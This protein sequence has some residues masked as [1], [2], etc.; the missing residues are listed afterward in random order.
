MASTE[1]SVII[2]EK[3]VV[4]SSSLESIV[5]V[6]KKRLAKIE[7]KAKEERPTEERSS[8]EEQQVITEQN[9]KQ[10]LDESEKVSILAGLGEALGALFTRSFD[11]VPVEQVPNLESFAKGIKSIDSWTPDHFKAEYKWLSTL[12]KDAETEQI[13]FPLRTYILTTASRKGFNPLFVLGLAED[14][15]SRI[16]QKPVVE[17]TDLE[18]LERKKDIFVADELQEK[19]DKFQSKLRNLSLSDWTEDDLHRAMEEWRDQQGDQEHTSTTKDI[20]ML[21]LKEITRRANLK[22][23]EKAAEKALELKSE[24]QAPEMVEAML[25]NEKQESA[26]AYIKGYLSEPQAVAFDAAQVVADTSNQPVDELFVLLHTVEE[27]SPH[28]SE[29]KIYSELGGIASIDLEEPKTQAVV[30]A[31]ESA[32]EVRDISVEEGFWQAYARSFDES[33]RAQLSSLSA[34]QL[35]Q[36]YGQLDHLV[37]E[38]KAKTKESTLRPKT[39]DD[40]F[41]SAEAF[42]EEKAAVSVGLDNNKVATISEDIDYV[43]DRAAAYYKTLSTA[44]VEK[45]GEDGFSEFLETEMR[46]K[47]KQEEASEERAAVAE[48]DRIIKE[49]RIQTGQEQRIWEELKRKHDV[50]E[51]RNV[52]ESARAKKEEIDFDAMAVE[53]AGVTDDTLRVVKAELLLGM[54]FSPEERAAL[55]Q[56]HYVGMGEKGK[57]GKAAGI[58]NYTNEQLFKKMQ[59]LKDA[60]FDKGQVRQLLWAGLAGSSGAA[61]AEPPAPTT[62]SGQ[63]NY[64]APDLDPQ[65]LDKITKEGYTPE[66]PRF[67][68][69]PFKKWE[70]APKLSAGEIASMRGKKELYT[71]SLDPH[72]RE[73]EY[74][75]VSNSLEQTAFKIGYSAPE[76]WGPSGKYPVYR[77]IIRG[78]KEEIISVNEANLR[79]WWRSRM[80]YYHEQSPTSIYD[81]FSKVELEM[82]LGKFNL[83]TILDNE[84]RTLRSARTGD[85]S[86]DLSKWLQLEPWL[87]S[88]VR[89][90]QIEYEKIMGQDAKLAEKIA[91]LFYWNPLTKFS[92]GK[93]LLSYASQLPEMEGSV[94]TAFN[95]YYNLSDH[96]K[97]VDLIGRDSAFFSKRAFVEALKAA[98][99]KN[100]ND[101][102]LDE[103]ELMLRRGLFKA[104]GM[105]NEKAFFPDID[106]KTGKTVKKGGKEQGTTGLKWFM[107]YVNIW[108]EQTPNPGRRLLVQNLVRSALV[109]KHQMYTLDNDGTYAE[110]TD[111]ASFAELTAYHMQRAFGGGSRNDLTYRSFDKQRALDGL[112]GVRQKYF[113]KER[114]A[115]AGNNY[116]LHQFK[117]LVVNFLEGVYT[118]SMRIGK[119]GLP[120]SAKLTPLE[121]FEEID[122]QT[123]NP[124]AKRKLLRGRMN[125][126]YKTYEKLMGSLQAEAQTWEKYYYYSELTKFTRGKLDSIRARL[127]ELQGPLTQWDKLLDE[128][129]ERHQD[130]LQ[131]GEVLDEALLFSRY[132]ESGSSDDRKKKFFQNAFKHKMGDIQAQIDALAKTNP[133]SKKLAKLR[134]DLSWWT[135][136]QNEINQ[137]ISQGGTFAVDYFRTQNGKKLM[138][139]YIEYVTAYAIP[140]MPGAVNRA[141]KSE[142]DLEYEA[143]SDLQGWITLQDQ[144]NDYNSRHEAEMIH[145]RQRRLELTADFERYEAKQEAARIQTDQL[146]PRNLTHVEQA[147]LARLQQLYPTLIHTEYYED[148]LGRMDRLDNRKFGSKTYKETYADFI[149]LT[150]QVSAS[151]KNI[152]AMDSEITRLEKES[153]SAN[154]AQLQKRRQERNAEEAKLEKAEADLFDINQRYGLLLKSTTAEKQ[155]LNQEQRESMREAADKLTFEDNTMRDWSNNHYGRAAKVMDYI[156][157][158]GELRLEKYTQHDTFKG[159]SFNREE[160]QKEFQENLSKTYRYLRSTY[161]K[162][163]YDKP[164]RSYLEEPEVDEKGKLQ[165]NDDGTVKMKRKWMDVPLGEALFGYEVVNRPE[166]W[167]LDANG[168]P[169]FKVV[170]AGTNKDGS[171]KYKQTKYHEI[172][173]GKVNKQK[174]LLW[175][176][177]LM[178]NIAGQLW[179]HRDWHSTDPRYDF[180]YYEKV[181]DVLA[182]IPASVGGD[183]FHFRNSRVMSYFFDKD[184]IKW[185]RKLS[186]TRTWDLYWPTFFGAM[187]TRDK[188]DKDDPVTEFWKKFFGSIVAQVA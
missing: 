37:Q 114:G 144:V 120:T 63:E 78:D 118:N 101:A 175:K 5:E 127:A 34:G 50:H 113:S 154:Q 45:I 28:M 186:N 89:Q 139:W 30:K 168:Q 172:D 26:A 64:F 179:A 166:F 4:A 42:T 121:L 164:T 35:K 160:F 132:L 16:V 43:D 18:Q 176:R 130:N 54:R 149:R 48:V 170:Q 24:G 147:N 68:E 184:D 47:T 85:K 69:N 141:V 22:A 117:Q 152:S 81:F 99:K 74:E 129:R 159:I 14:S 174:L 107:K 23:Q 59:I 71:F 31:Y 87:L 183:E 41:Y 105:L 123:M 155:S 9:E 58:Y 49:S 116:T 110:D 19:L 102:S 91:E 135:E 7:E 95:I 55:L 73:R 70:N 62:G 115:A 185:L 86:D 84:D 137:M 83:Y 21:L 122:R 162:I 66:N 94:T 148:L 165:F 36:A 39:T 75:A 92:F 93:S 119:D 151:T 53:N 125:E 12:S 131:P 180:R 6:A 140:E 153:L 2:I 97:L 10:Q 163:Q 57:D 150:N 77:S 52:V 76:V 171:P 104:D 51:E 32:I 106:I 173:W 128:I 136:R 142:R 13:Y 111:A 126:Y 143:I 79:R 109:H 182:H 187:F 90:I 25:E 40:S 15:S 3:P 188:S 44:L 138:H 88:T 161:G 103:A 108:P 100:P 80:V 96:D 112:K 20:Q 177:E 27:T 82:R 1:S 38:L 157:G 98:R 178:M 133:A 181:I 29:G 156:L 46:E 17:V 8:Q 169:V 11:Q 33:I 124:E 167:K 65:I 67:A 56:A 134:G 145:L 146:N 158:A 60:G 61:V 72:E